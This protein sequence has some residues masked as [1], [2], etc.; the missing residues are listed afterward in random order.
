MTEQTPDQIQT[1]IESTEASY[2]SVAAELAAL[3]TVWESACAQGDD[4]EAD[5]A[6]EELD[7]LKRQQRRYEL[8]L[9]ALH[10]ELDAAEDRQRED[11][12]KAINAELVTS[13]SSLAGKLAKLEQ[14]REKLIQQMEQARAEAIAMQATV[15]ELAAMQPD[16]CEAEDTLRQF[17]EP[18]FDAV[19]LDAHNLSSAAKNLRGSLAGVYR[20]AHSIRFDAY[21]RR[22][23]EQRKAG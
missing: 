9:D 2:N 19:G 23:A 10:R 11:R 12:V 7:T 6:E 4:T 22:Q 21:S 5:K 8:R 17:A 20:L 1:L 15:N 13:A 18:A 14:Q 3:T 16:T